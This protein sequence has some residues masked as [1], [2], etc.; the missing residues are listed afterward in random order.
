MA[1]R[2]FSEILLHLT[3]HTE[4]NARGT[5]N[6]RL[7]CIESP[8]EQPAGVNAGGDKEKGR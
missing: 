5:L 6:N 4:G 7:E 3:W 1:H 8:D 2:A